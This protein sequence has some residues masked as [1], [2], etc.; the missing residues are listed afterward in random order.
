MRLKGL[1][2]MV[3]TIKLQILL[4]SIGFI[5]LFISKNYIC[6]FIKWGIL[7]LGLLIVFFIL[8][9]SFVLFYSGV[10]VETGNSLSSMQVIKYILPLLIITI[11]FFLVFKLEKE[12]SF[13]AS[14][15][16]SIFLLFYYYRTSFH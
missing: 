15:I 6:D 12:L 13:G 9:E 1:P 10:N 11:P 4:T 8:Q 5:C 16:S 7:I 2:Q 3:I 14:F